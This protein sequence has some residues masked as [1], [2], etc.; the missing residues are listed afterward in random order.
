MGKPF[1]IHRAW[2]WLVFD[3]F[4]AQGDEEKRLGL[5][6]GMLNDRDKINKPGSQHGF[7]NFLVSPLVFSTVKVFQPLFH[8][9]EQMGSN[10]TE[11]RN[12]WVTETDPP[13]EDL[14]KKDADILKIDDEIEALRAR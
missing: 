4:F 7:I 11:W 2:A 13:E 5:P 8:L 6:V 9:A 1:V 12:I 14:A 3:E 10:L